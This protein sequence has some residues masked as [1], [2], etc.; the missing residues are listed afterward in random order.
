VKLFAYY[1]LTPFAARQVS[2]YGGN[3][4]V[5]VAKRGSRT[6]GSSV[7]ELLKLEA[8]AGLDRPD[9]YARFAQRAEKAKFDLLKLALDCKETGASFV[10]N[11]CPGRCSTLLNYVGI[12]KGLM[13]YIAEQPT[14]LKLGRYLPGKHIPIVDNERL[15]REQP[16]YVVLLAWHYAEPI[17]AQLRDRGLRSKLV[18]PLPELRIL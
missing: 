13:P 6:V 7:S 18:V 9:T 17:A 14:S 4:R 2:R 5:Y 12:D 10:G 11:S 8:E 3:I 15:F 16:D 1:D